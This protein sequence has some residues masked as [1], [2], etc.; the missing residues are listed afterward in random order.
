MPVRV[1]GGRGIRKWAG[2]L[3]TLL[4]YLKVLRR[5]WLSIVVCA[6]LGVLAGVGF[7]LVSPKAY[8]AT[9]TSFVASTATGADASGNSIYAGSQFAASQAQ[10]YVLLVSSPLVLDPVIKDLSLKMTVDELRGEVSASSPQ[11]SVIIHVTATDRNAALAAQIATATAKEL[12]KVIQQTVAPHINGHSLITVTLTQPALTPSAPSSPRRTLNVALGFIV[13]L[14]VGVILAVARQRLD[15]SITSPDDLQAM[16]AMKPLGVIGSIKDLHKNPLLIDSDQTKRYAEAFRRIRS[17]LQFVDVD[18]PPRA[19]VVTSAM[20]GEG[21]TVTS[22]N[23]AIAMAQ[24][25]ARVCVVD[26]DLRIPKVAEFFGVEGGVGL[27]NVL[28]GQHD[29]DD[30]LISWRRDLLTVLAAGTLPSDPSAVLGSDAMAET[31]RELRDRF[32]VLIIDVPPLLPVADASIVA[33]LG[34]GAVLVA[35]HRRTTREHLRHALDAL[36][37][38]DA[39]LLGTVLTCVPISR[40]LARAYGYGYSVAPSAEAR[41]HAAEVDIVTEV[42]GR[43]SRRAEAK[44]AD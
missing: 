23:L 21:K 36:R 34:D 2:D 44:R 18:H 42:P 27:T 14:A 8:T 32:D 30:V 15:T 28:A 16:T 40:A 13:G 25:G 38:A 6:V 26:A 37:A 5:R 20:P 41:K 33:R 3:M 7:T 9:T 4:D 39:R 17:S 1:G 22:C 43:R 24:A 12:G 11:N 31:M 19:I 35:R 10:S 29:L